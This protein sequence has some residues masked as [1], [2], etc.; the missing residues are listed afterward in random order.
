ML[1]RS[2]WF[3]LIWL[4]HTAILYAQSRQENVDS[5]QVLLRAH[6]QKDTFHIDLL[7][8]IAW[9]YLNPDPDSARYYSEKANALAKQLNYLHGRGHA[10]VNIGRYYKDKGQ[11]TKALGLLLQAVKLYEADG[12][13][14]QMAY[15]YTD[16]GIVHTYNSN[17][18]LALE[19]FH[20]AR[21]LFELLDDKKGIGLWL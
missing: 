4:S 19:S 9:E 6:P 1:S 14:S 7:N 10:V 20:N 5:L 17:K 13:E 8:A 18:V 2:F 12:D 16:I 3:L 15:T 11:L 21:K